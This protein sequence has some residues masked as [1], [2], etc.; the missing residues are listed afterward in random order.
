MW[1]LRYLEPGDHHEKC[2]CALSNPQVRGG[3]PLQ[4]WFQGD[5]SA[6]GLVRLVGYP[7]CDCACVWMLPADVGALVIGNEQCQRYDKRPLVLHLCRLLSGYF[8]LCILREFLAGESSQNAGRTELS[9]IGK[10]NRPSE[11][12][13]IRCYLHAVR[14]SDVDDLPLSPDTRGGEDRG[15]G[16]AVCCLSCYVQLLCRSQVHV[17]GRVFLD[18]DVEN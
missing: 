11:H 7:V 17:S 15:R 13:D 9:R 18:S 6:T 2:A 4:D 10:G 5:E 8:F 14:M 1:D 3:L 16:H 12:C